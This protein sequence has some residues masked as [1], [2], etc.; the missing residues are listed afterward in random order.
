MFL[1]GRYQTH[2]GG[3]VDWRKSRL[4]SKKCGEKEQE[5][6]NKLCLRRMKAVCMEETNYIFQSLRIRGLTHYCEGILVYT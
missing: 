6:R 4:W 3:R 1:E 5:S 2:D